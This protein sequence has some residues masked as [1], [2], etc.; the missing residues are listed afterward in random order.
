MRH[1]CRASPLQ[2]IKGRESAAPGK[3]Y[4]QRTRQWVDRSAGTGL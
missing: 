4:G 2:G 3:V 1:L